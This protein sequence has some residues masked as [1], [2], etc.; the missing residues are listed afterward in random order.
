MKTVLCVIGT[1]PEAIK[2]AP[3]VLELAHH[4]NAVAPFVCLTSQHRDLV[5]PVLDLFGITPH[6][7]LAVMRPD[8]SLA[9]LTAACMVGLDAAIADVQPACVLGQG[10][11]TTAL[12]ASLAAYYR[13]IPFGHVEAGLRTRDRYRPFPE[14]MN[15]TVADHI[16]EY[17]FAPTLRSREALLRE[18]IEPS[19]VLVTGNTVVDAVRAIGARPYAWDQGPLAAMDPTG[20]L[21]L[22]TAHRRESFGRGIDEMLRALGDLAG[23]HPDVTFVYPV[24]PNPNV[25]RVARERFTGSPNVALLP[26]LEYDA[27]IHLMQ[28]SILVLTDSGG[29]QEEAVALGVPVLVM[30]ETTERPEGIDAGGAR[31]VG[32]SRDTTVREAETLLQH[33][34]FRIAMTRTRD[35][36]GDG[37]ASSRIVAHLMGALL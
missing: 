21:V 3:V 34:D 17:L 20:R 10:D 7:D 29:L 25:S 15:R 37:T 5:G 31:L 18:G 24:H 23:R 2:M 33:R 1:R 22:F 35:V 8:Q 6:L 36:Y 14:E 28:R 9:E 11:T 13:R 32:T 30:R 26:P 4:P 19:R 12:T 16:A 27:T